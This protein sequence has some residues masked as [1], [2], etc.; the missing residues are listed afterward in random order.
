MGQFESGYGLK[1]VTLSRDKVRIYGKEEL[2]NSINSVYVMIDISGLSGDKTYEKLPIAG[3]EKINKLSFDT[4]D[5]SLKFHLQL[6][7]QLQIYL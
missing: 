2:L 1:E 7:K 3:I 4:V 5:A 6:K